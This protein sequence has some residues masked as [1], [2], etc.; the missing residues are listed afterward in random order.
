MPR[1]TQKQRRAQTRDRLLA[2]AEELFA[3]RGYHA[4]SLDQI[5]ARAD[6]SRGALHYN[7]GGKEDLFLSLLE[8]QLGTRADQLKST[9]ASTKSSGA[10]A[11]GLVGSLPFDRRFSLLFLEFACEAA[12]NPEVATKLRQRLA[13]LREPVTVAAERFLE[14]AEIEGAPAA[15]L[16]EATSALVNGLSIEALAG[17]D[18]DVLN[19]RFALILGL[20]LDGLRSRG[21]PGA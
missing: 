10:L 9:D 21:A 5:A 14:T 7:F 17:V 16:V 12:R 4:V 6:Y 2:A 3:E 15:E 19:A 11:D 18:I 20:V 13:Q 1:L 8:Q